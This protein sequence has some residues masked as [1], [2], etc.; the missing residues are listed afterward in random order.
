MPTYDQ[1]SGSPL[2][3]KKTRIDAEYENLFATGTKLVA[4]EEQ[5]TGIR[6]SDN[7]NNRELIFSRLRGKRAI[8][9]DF[10]RRPDIG[11]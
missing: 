4:A 5:R 1:A 11:A 2:R 9:E 10:L 6:T 3:K 7:E 8:S